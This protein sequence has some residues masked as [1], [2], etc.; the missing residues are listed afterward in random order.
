[1]SGYFILNIE[2]V[3]RAMYSRVSQA[4]FN[5][6]E[7]FELQ[8]HSDHQWPCSL[9]LKNQF[10]EHF[11]DVFF[12]FWKKSDHSDRQLLKDALKQS[13]FCVITWCYNLSHG[14]LKDQ[15]LGDELMGLTDIIVE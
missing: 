6:R 3:N 4:S 7:I 12:T 1:M 13:Y 5:I 11:S 14:Q 9:H 8:S 10:F 2:L 15:S